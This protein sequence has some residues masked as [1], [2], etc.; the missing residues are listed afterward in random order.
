ML[1]NLCISW[2]SIPRSI[3]SRR[4][5]AEA[6]GWL[7]E[8]RYPLPIGRLAWDPEPSVRDA[9][10]R[11]QYERRERRYAEEYMEHVL[12]VRNPVEVIPAWRYG[13][14][15]ART[16]DDQ[17]LETIEKHESGFPLHPSI[18]SWLRRIRET[19]KKRWD[20]VVEKWP[21]PSYSRRGRLEVVSG[22]IIDG[23]GQ[24]LPFEGYLWCAPTEEVTSVQ[25]WGGWTVSAMMA[26]A[27]Y[28]IKIPN[29]REA[30]L[31][32]VN[33]VYPNGPTIFRGKG[34]F[35]AMTA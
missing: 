11:A 29:R 20:G 35:P 8:D 6:S 33:S 12:S 16:G 14:A 34:Q 32:V 30:R 15:L 27:E 10:A 19:L 7:L 17:A 18:R 21:D 4:R 3:E 22:K 13:E 9:F 26:D 2:A 5:S 24:E 31:L 1:R 23:E 25:S 28:T